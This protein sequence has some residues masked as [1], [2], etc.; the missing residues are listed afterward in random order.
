MLIPERICRLIVASL[1]SVSML[2]ATPAPAA[3]R[4]ENGKIVFIAN[5]TGVTNFI[6]SIPMVPICLGCPQALPFPDSG[7]PGR[8]AVVL[9]T[10]GGG[11]LFGS[12]PKAILALP[13]VP[14]RSASRVCSSFLP[15]PR[16]RRSK[17]RGHVRGTTRLCHPCKYG[18][19]RKEE[20]LD[21]RSPRTQRQPQGHDP[22]ARFSATT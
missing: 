15:P 10:D 9:P 6:L 7:P 11:V 16:A 14:V 17:V 19:T 2:C 21:A 13:D 1:A 5:I 12:E 20:I 8:E 4:G 22:A 18:R 3:D